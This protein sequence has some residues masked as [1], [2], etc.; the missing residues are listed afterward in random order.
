MSYGLQRG[1]I[2]EE[3]RRLA[4]I[5]LKSFTWKKDENLFVSAKMNG[6]IISCYWY[7]VLE[8]LLD[9][10]EY[11]DTFE[12]LEQYKEYMFEIDEDYQD[13]DMDEEIIAIL[14][15]GKTAY[16]SSCGNSGV[17]YVDDDR[18]FVIKEL[19]GRDNECNYYTYDEAMEN[20]QG[21][22]KNLDEDL[23]IGTLS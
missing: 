21:D 13:S 19:I 15:N 3:E 5:E 2:G 20:L 16:R 6:R 7:K 14:N 12:N 8:E 18:D 23:V 10:N 4:I 22:F 17:S 9:E 1:F 11:L